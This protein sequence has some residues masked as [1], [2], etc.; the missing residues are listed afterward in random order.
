FY[1]ENTNLRIKHGLNNHM[2][3]QLLMNISG[4]TT[5]AGIQ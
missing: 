1:D 4:T 3:H 5:G 2:P